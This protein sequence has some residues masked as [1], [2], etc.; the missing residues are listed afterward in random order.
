[1]RQR[2]CT[3]R[4]QIPR[5]WSTS[6]PDGLPVASVHFQNSYAFIKLQTR[7]VTVIFPVLAIMPHTV[8][9]IY[10]SRLQIV[11]SW[12][13]LCLFASAQIVE[14]RQ[15]ENSNP[16]KLGTKTRVHKRNIAVPRGTLSEIYLV[17]K[18][19]DGA[20]E[21]TNQPSYARALYKHGYAKLIRLLH[22]L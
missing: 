17:S 10:H 2:E 19:L 9:Q 21:K 20:T 7:G 14:R 18:P 8:S 13:Y 15:S 16:P 5:S 3:S 4:V 12:N 11:T 6:S 1:M 22:C